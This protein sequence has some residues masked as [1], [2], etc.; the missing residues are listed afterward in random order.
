[1]RNY[2]LIDIQL[3]ILSQ[4]I[5]KTNRT[6]VPK[7]ED[8]SHTNLYFDA[9][10]NRIYG[11]WIE[12]KSDKILLS[13]SLKEHCFQWLNKKLQLLQ[14]VS[15]LNKTFDEI[16]KEIKQ[17]LPQLNLSTEGFSNP[18]HYEI[19]PYKSFKKPFL[20]FDE[21]GLSNWILFRQLANQACNLLSGYLQT[22]AETRIWPHH[23]DTGVYLE[24]HQNLGI[25]FGLAMKDD[26][27]GDAYF[28]LSG[29]KLD[30]TTFN[31]ETVSKSTYGNWH[32]TKN[33]KG[34]VLPLQE[35]QKEPSQKLN[36]FLKDTTNWYLNN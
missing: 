14:S 15:I 1:M 24:P 12:T 5:A 2:Y 11:R 27:V 3:H 13:F 20:K 9:I 10:E 29:Y 18:L 7:K 35:I 19:P 17:T 36:R 23:F 34:A 28:Y 30:E 33:W 16:E 32:I 6:F 21:I 26:R 25:G 31:F 8:D 22:K 4:I